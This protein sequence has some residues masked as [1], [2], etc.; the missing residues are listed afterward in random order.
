[1]RFRSLPLWTGFLPICGIIA[2]YVTAASL[3]HVESCFPFI[4]GCTSISSTGRQAPEAYIFRATVMPGAILILLYWWQNARLLRDLGDGASTTARLLPWLG[5]FAAA[6]LLIY[7]SVLGAIGEVHALQR[8]VGVTVFF[9]SNLVAQ[10]L[11]TKRLLLLAQNG[12]L[13][14]ARPVVDAKLWICGLMLATGLMIIPK[15]LFDWDTDNIV[16]WNFALLTHLYYVSTYFL[17]RSP[18]VRVA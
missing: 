18:S 12:V 6:F 10:L 1:M 11:F 7:A 16:E 3:G 4:H 17:W 14:A 2:S 5:V 8:R 9:A 15:Y 13:E